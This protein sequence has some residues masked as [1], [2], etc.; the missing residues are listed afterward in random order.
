M[1]KETEKQDKPE[2]LRDYFA[3]AAL[4]GMLSCPVRDP[5]EMYMARNAYFYADEMMKERNKS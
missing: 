1:E 5:A 3:M 2:T 4:T